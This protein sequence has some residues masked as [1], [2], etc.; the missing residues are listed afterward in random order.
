MPFGKIDTA[1]LEM[2]KCSFEPNA[3]AMILFDKADINTAVDSIV[4]YRHKR[5]KLFEG[6]D[7]TL[8]NVRLVYYSRDNYEQISE[9]SAESITWENNAV[10]V[11]RLDPKMIYT[12]EVDKSQK[13]VVFTFPGVKAGAVI[14]YRYKWK[15]ITPANFPKWYFQDALPTRYSVVNILVPQDLDYTTITKGYQDF[16]VDNTQVVFD[17]HLRGSTRHH[18]AKINLPGFVKEEFISPGNMNLQSVTMRINKLMHNA[19]FMEAPDGTWQRIVRYLAYVDNFGE[20]LDKSISD[21]SAILKQV[22]G[23]ATDREKIAYLFN[24]VKTTMKWNGINSWYTDEGIRKAWS[25]KTGNVTEINLILHNLLRKAGIDARPMVVSTPEHGAILPDLAGFSQ[26]NKTVVYIQGDSTNYYVLDASNKYARFDEVPP[27]LLNTY[28]ISF[29]ISPLRIENQIV[30]LKATKPTVETVNVQAE[31]L[32]DGKVNGTSEMT[33][34]SYK[35]A[36]YHELYDKVGQRKYEDFIKGDDSRVRLDSLVLI[37]MGTDSLPLIQK[38]N[39]QI[40]LHASDDKYIYFTPNLFSPLKV[41]P[42]LSEKRLSDIDFGHPVYY[43]ISGKYK[44]PSGYKIDAMPRNLQVN[45]IDKS[46]ICKRFVSESDGYIE[47]NYTVTFKRSFY[48]VEEYR[49]LYDFYK[50]LF[51][52]LNEPVVLKKAS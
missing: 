23:L 31:I 37:N 10:V 22:K 33:S 17:E 42:F 12:E 19:L 30:L 2:T 39:F 32:P 11:T 38:F 16:A 44:L 52:V 47:L 20:Q 51:E 29:K 48:G 21:E 41:N 5:I 34:Y 46:I 28:G 18:L 14:E 13:A 3:Q 43:G 45:L 35:K 1:D 27:D 6:Y 36:A 26:I 49:S 7:R 8:A 50:R 4:M 40:D 9:I 24:T 15:T 25:K